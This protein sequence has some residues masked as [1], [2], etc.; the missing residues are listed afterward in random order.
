MFQNPEYQIIFPTVGEELIF[1]LLQLS[2]DQKVA[3]QKAR[4]LLN[5]YKHSDWFEKPVNQ[6]SNGERHLVCILAVVIMDPKVIVFDESLSSLDFPTRRKLLK[7]IKKLDQQ[8]IMISHDFESFK[9]FNQVIWLESGR[10]RMKGEP[11]EVI[12]AYKEDSILK[13]NAST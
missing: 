10:I 6:L 8:I 13:E 4:L 5:E 9:D 11:S 12:R 1:G 7:T 2:I 3:E